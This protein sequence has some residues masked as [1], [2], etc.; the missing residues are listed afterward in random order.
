MSPT[1]VDRLSAIQQK[2][3]SI[4]CIGIDPDPEKLPRHLV[5][6]KSLPEAVL[7]F[8]QEIIEATE[9]Y[10]CAFKLNLAF[11]EI[12]GADG[13]RVL[14]ET[15]SSISTET[16]TI[17][18]GKRGDIGN[19]AR[20]YAASVFER[21]NFD[22]CTVSPYMGRDSVLPFLQYKGKAAFVLAR[23]S[24]PGA[25][26]LQEIE[27]GGESMFLRVVRLVRQ[28]QTGAKGTAGLVAGATDLHALSA[29]R[30]AAP[31][32]PLL[33]P[34][35]GTQGGDPQAVLEIT[36]KGGAPVLVNSSR[37][38]LYAASTPEFASKA[39]DVA[40]SLRSTLRPSRLH[41]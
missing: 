4:L 32:L 38:I 14:E 5:S 24:N 28:W 34:G 37:Q 16:L 13:W 21:L 22:A 31:D 2:K 10:A 20:F 3:Q 40:Q 29:V 7:H 19:S 39:A 33:I 26:D 41:Q 25:A 17:A 1:F 9:P 30:E 11:F 35:V 27:P 15:V 8:C 6:E 23:T 12:L 18:D 36:G